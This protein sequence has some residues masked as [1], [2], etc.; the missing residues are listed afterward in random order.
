[1]AK[2]KVIKINTSKIKKSKKSQNI[3]DKY[4]I[5]KISIIIIISAIIFFLLLLLLLEASI[6]NLNELILIKKEK[7]YSIKDSCSLIVGKLIHPIKN[8]E[9]CEQLCKEK[10]ILSKEIYLKVEF[11]ENQDNCNQC[12][13]Y[14]K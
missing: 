12:T 6:I 1:M 4:K 9:T 8:I 10:C 13:C 11:T 7:S 2:K 3:N 5:I 14:C